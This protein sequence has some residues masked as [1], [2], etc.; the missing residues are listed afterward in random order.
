LRLAAGRGAAAPSGGLDGSAAAEAD[1]RGGGRA[2]V[3]AAR[4]ASGREERP[5]EEG[6]G[7]PLVAGWT[8][9][10]FANMA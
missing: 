3:V 1:L 4:E 6:L 2:S 9:I 8:A 7:R 10:F 5:E